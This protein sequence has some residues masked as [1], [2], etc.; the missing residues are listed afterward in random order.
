MSTIP[1]TY[2]ENSQQ[3][4]IP[5]VFDW[6]NYCSYRSHRERLDWSVERVQLMYAR[7]GV[8]SLEDIQ[9]WEKR[10]QE[11]RGCYEG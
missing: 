11:E 8:G 9:R 2:N 4:S 6:L 7:N 5:D 3:L 1:V 10:F